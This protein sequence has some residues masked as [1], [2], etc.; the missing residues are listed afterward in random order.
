[1]VDYEE[2]TQFDLQMMESKIFSWNNKSCFAT[3]HHW[4]THYFLKI[5]LK[6]APLAP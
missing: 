5:H 3:S 4:L 2:K 6:R 1:M